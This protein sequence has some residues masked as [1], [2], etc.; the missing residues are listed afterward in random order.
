L[1]KEPF[2]FRNGAK[3]DLVRLKERLIPYELF[4][5]GEFHLFGPSSSGKTTAFRVAAS[6]YAPPEYIRQ[7][8]KPDNKGKS[9]QS[10]TLPN[11]GKKRVYVF[12][13]EVFEEPEK[14]ERGR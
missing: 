4:E 11:L 14:K 9:S 8:L 1:N 13:S 6:A 2:S 10:V 3:T 5:F 12:Y 7:W